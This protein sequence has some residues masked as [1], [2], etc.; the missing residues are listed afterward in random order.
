MNDSK[1]VP[2]E[3]N[4]EEVD[5]RGFFSKIFMFVGLI[6][7]YGAF[8]LTALRYL[9]PAKAAPKSWMFVSD[10]PSF[11]KGKSISYKS[12]SGQKVTI[13]RMGDEGKVED[14][15]ALSSVCPHL[16]CQV[17]WEANNDRFFC[18]CH[19]GVFNATG[20]P[21]EGPP[22][23]ANQELPKYKLMVEKNLLFIEV[24]EALI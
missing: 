23:E 16:G 1:D 20:K 3:N 18:P 5:R 14:F 19:N 8:G 12:P 9:Y 17:H 21:T 6:G 13:T 24:N 11:N 2:A 15:I 10:L 22:A 7:G 4:S